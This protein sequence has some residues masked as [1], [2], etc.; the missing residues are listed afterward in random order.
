MREARRPVGTAAGVEGD[1][2]TVLVDL[3]AISVKLYLVEPALTDG[4]AITR[5]G[6]AGT[7]EGGRTRQGPYVEVAKGP[8]NKA[9][10]LVGLPVKDVVLRSQVDGML[11]PRLT[12]RRL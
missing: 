6:L 2:L 11:S 3:E 1:L 5:N 12:L 4:K 9:S 7:D 10:W 8:S